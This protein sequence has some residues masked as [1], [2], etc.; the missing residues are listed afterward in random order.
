VA[1]P[2]SE[3]AKPSRWRRRP[4]RP[5]L[6]CQNDGSAHP[7]GVGSRLL[8]WR[9]PRASWR[10]RS[11]IASCAM[12]M[13]S[14]SASTSGLSRPTGRIGVNTA[15]SADRSKAPPRRLTK[16][17]KLCA[18][19]QVVECQRWRRARL[20]SPTRT[21]LT[22]PGPRWQ[23]RHLSPKPAGPIT[24]YGGTES[25]G[26]RASAT[27]AGGGGGLYPCFWSEEWGKT[28]S[29]ASATTSMLFFNGL[30]PTLFFGR[31]SADRQPT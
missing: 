18:V 25:G 11:R 2:G 3:V 8:T 24:M 23:K 19:A 22:P 5:S 4:L 28:A 20:P 10:N 6:E 30:W 21:R 9:R 13:A 14:S 29:G 16:A 1:F 15:P 12:A 17:T 27:A 31:A 7:H 26:G